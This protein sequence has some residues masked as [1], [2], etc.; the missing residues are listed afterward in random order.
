MFKVTPLTQRRLDNFRA[1]RRGYWSFWIFLVF[2]VLT[3]AAEFISNDKPILVVY[4]KQIYTP[5]FV[6]YPETAF[7][8]EFETEANYRDKFVSDLINKKGWM[9][10]PPIHYSYNT[11]NYALPVPAPAPPSIEKVTHEVSKWI[12]WPE[13]RLSSP[14][15]VKLPGTNLAPSTSA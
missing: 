13:E 14:H 8:G 5:V 1:N 12:L 3:G 7:G 15:A 10:W 2:F 4:N 11:I 6:S 9:L